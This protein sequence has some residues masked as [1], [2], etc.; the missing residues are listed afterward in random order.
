MKS[1]FGYFDQFGML[2]TSQIYAQTFILLE[3]FPSEFSQVIDFIFE[4]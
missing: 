1:S 4:R 3:T 2:A